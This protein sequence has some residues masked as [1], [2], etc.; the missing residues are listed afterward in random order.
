MFHTARRLVLAVALTALA[1]GSIGAAPVTALAQPRF[2]STESKYAAIV[3]DASTG[4]VLYEK[5]PDAQR[6]PASIS[7][8]MTL[9]LTFEALS[10]GRLKLTDQLVVSAHAA[11]MAP[12]KLGVPAGGTISVDEAMRGVAV[13]SANDMAVALAERIGGSESRF[14]AL[15]TLRAQE[16]GMVN[17]HYVNASGLPD[18][19]QISSARD[20]AILSRSVM[21]DYPQYYSYFSIKHLDWHGQT[22]N[23]HNGLLLKMPGVDGLKTGFINASGFNLAASAV[24]DNRRLIAVVLGGNSTAARDA[25]VEDLLDTGFVVLQ[26]RAMGQKIDFAQNL[27]EPAP[28]GVISR[29]PTEE[30]SADQ[31]GVKIVLT[32]NEQASL[33]AATGG[34]QGVSAEQPSRQG[35]LHADRPARVILA[36]A[37]RTESAA[38]R[39]REEREAARHHDD[40]WTV[41]VG[42]YKA[43]GQAHSQ[44]SAIARKYAAQL[45]D[46]EGGVDGEGHTWRARFAGLSQA[47]AKE[48]CRALHAHHEACQ[49]VGPG[50]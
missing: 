45:R 28:I 32:N 33:R 11:S 48:A 38:Q 29:E 14:A 6:Y 22:I 8:I 44:V 5:N 13:K 3:M 46:A 18:V 36:N 50:R 37:D 41:Q 23:N 49:V 1:V 10:T 16:L 7:K 21:R 17:T 26:R 30:G 2:V 43:R 24:R 42:A 27:A 35:G 19:R 15:M 12:S 39:I 25:H 9:Y 4:E 34:G 31:S 20:I 47:D 40:S